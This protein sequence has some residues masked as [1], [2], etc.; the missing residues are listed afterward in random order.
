MKVIFFESAAGFGAW[1]D[2]NH[3]TAVELWVGFY[4]KG[5]GRLNLSWPESVD[6][7]LC[8]GWIDGVRKSLDE[9]SYTIRFSPRKQRSVWS[10]VNVRRVEELTKQGV[11]RPAGLK[12][13]E[14]RQENRSGIYSYEQ[15]SAELPSQ[16]AQVLKKN[17]AAWTF[18]QTQPP[19]YRKA[20]HWWVV[21]AKKEETRVKR[22]DALIMHSAKR[23]RLPQY[24]A[25]KKAK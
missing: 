25:L 12:A 22:L 14:A 8:V 18:F 16:Y 4:K 20:V 24:V 15:R 6:Q 13:F 19:S 17:K 5:S 2:A 11:M 1:L 23:Q 9:V 10:S 7:A 3:A 21:S